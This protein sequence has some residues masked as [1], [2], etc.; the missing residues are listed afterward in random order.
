[1]HEPFSGYQKYPTQNW[2]IWAS[3]QTS[4]KR[5]HKLQEAIWGTVINEIF[6]FAPLFVSFCQVNYFYELSLSYLSCPTQKWH[7]W[8]SFQTSTKRFGK[9]QEVI[10]VTVNN[11]IFE[12]PPHFDSFGFLN[13]CMSSPQATRIIQLKNDT[14]ELVFRLLERDF[15][16][17]R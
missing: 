3:F 8:A 7:I 6:E 14:F 5:F 9:L 10:W 11:N 17:Y 13:Y 15:L 4:G 2:Y 1:M 16:N 12:F